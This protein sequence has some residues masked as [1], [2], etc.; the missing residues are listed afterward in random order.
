[1]HEISCNVQKKVNFKH[2]FD[3]FLPRDVITV[4][5]TDLLLLVGRV[6]FKDTPLPK[7]RR[8]E[9]QLKCQS[10]MITK[11]IKGSH[12]PVFDMK[13]GRVR[14]RYAFLCTTL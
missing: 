1:M 5:N 13:Q 12:L 10:N 9:S 4:P 3:G 14:E 7:D 11:R 8:A 6:I 2:R